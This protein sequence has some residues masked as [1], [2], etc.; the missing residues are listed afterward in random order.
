MWGS[1]SMEKFKM[2]KLANHAVLKLLILFFSLV[3][4]ISIAQ[5]A[6]QRSFIN[7][8]FESPKIANTGNACRVYIDSTKVPGWLTTHP[9]YQ[10][11]IRRSA[12]IIYHKMKRQYLQAG[13]PKKCLLTAY[14]ALLT[15][16]LPPVDSYLLPLLEASHHRT[17]PLAILSHLS[18]NAF[19]NDLR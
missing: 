1:N 3:S 19:C 14:K 6:Y 9:Y 15:L 2:M 10:D 11:A 18:S 12:Q 5:A 7:L 8:S 4:S 17:L 16:Y 13:L